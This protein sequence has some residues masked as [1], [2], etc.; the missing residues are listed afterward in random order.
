[1]KAKIMTCAAATLLASTAHAQ[2]SVTLFGAIDAGLTWV[3]NAGGHSN[4]FMQGGISNNT[5]FG[6]SAIEDLGGGTRAIAKLLNTFDIGTGSLYSPGQMFRYSF[7]GL[8]NDQ[9][10]RLTM[11]LQTDFMFN[12]MTI[13][14]WGPMLASLEPTFTQG[15]PFP[16][17]GAPAFGSM[18]FLRTADL[19]STP[20]AVTY[21]SPRMGGFK[22]GAMYGFGGV[23]GAFGQ[24][25]T[26][27]FGLSYNTGPFALDAAYTYTKFPTIDNGN[28]G[29]RDWG[30]GGRMPIG[31][32]FAALMVAQAINTD[33][34]ARV[35]VYDFA[36][37]YPLTPAAI[38]GFEYQFNDGNHVVNDV[39]MHQAGL[40][41]A[42]YL[43]KRTSVYAFAVYQHA[44][45]GAP[46]LIP[47][48]G[49]FSTSGNQAMVRI[50]MMH[51]W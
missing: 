11:G 31:N 14:R 5:G 37:T 13:D 15:G 33:N 21:E 18:D 35:M 9:M 30:V 43:S 47:G 16:Q 4:T 20:N 40:N 6:I 19:Y 10:G 49:A 3:S 50:G 24:N 32:G 39:K 22:F 2:S 36:A 48:S 25:S 1:V 34:N 44:S 17:L 28:S 38:V 29:L 46:A 45:N 41:F 7:V 42:Y 23:A 8:D 26:Q 27:S 12:Y 51:T